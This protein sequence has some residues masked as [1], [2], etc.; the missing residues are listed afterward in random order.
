MCN[1]GGSWYL[2]FM[3]EGNRVTTEGDSERTPEYHEQGHKGIR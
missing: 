3:P 2:K 1:V